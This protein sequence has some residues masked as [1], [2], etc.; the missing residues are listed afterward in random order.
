MRILLTMLL[1]GAAVGCE[2]TIKEVK[3]PAPHV[4]VPSRV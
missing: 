3:A 1:V 2:K 4:D